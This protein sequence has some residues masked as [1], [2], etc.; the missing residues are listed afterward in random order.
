MG[1]ELHPAHPGFSDAL[2]A[3]KATVRTTVQ[4]LGVTFNFLMVVYAGFLYELY[5]KYD[6]FFSIPS[7]QKH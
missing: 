2:A 6:S 7:F 4:L 3:V 5:V 1:S